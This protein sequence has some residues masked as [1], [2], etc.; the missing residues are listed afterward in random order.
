MISLSN[1]LTPLV[2][3]LGIGGVGGFLVGFALKKAAKILAVIVGLFFLSLQYLA[4]E[5]IISIDYSAL[6][7]FANELLGQT[8]GAQTWLTAF[9]VHAPFG[10]TF[11]GGLYLGLQK[12]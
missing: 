3:E 9:I 6:Q 7:A 8:T 4:Y 10:A 5:N 2:G 12:G 11:I 1:L